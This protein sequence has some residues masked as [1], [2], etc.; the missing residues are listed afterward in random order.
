MTIGTQIAPA[1]HGYHLRSFEERERAF[2]SAE[3]HSR[4]V[5]LLRKGLPALA[6]L[7]LAGYFVSTSMSVTVGDVTASIAGI[8]VSNGNLR[9]VN[10]KLKGADKKNGPY[11]ISADYADQD[12]KNPNLIELH[13]IKADVTSATGDGWSKMDAVRGTFNSKREYLIMKEQ[14]NVQTSSGVV[15]RLKRASLDMKTQTLRSHYPVAFDMTNGTVRSNAMTFQSSK[16]VLIF[17]GKVKVHLNKMKS[18]VNA[19]AAAKAPQVKAPAT[20]ARQ[21]P[22][23]SAVTTTEK[24]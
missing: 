17:R 3:R 7:T 24:R 18:D 19:K 14:I 12:M 10:P 13:S 23:Q 2:L 22:E 9:M 20:P 21:S 4:H 6:V 16:N 11:V 15:G 8:E 1:G 5:Q